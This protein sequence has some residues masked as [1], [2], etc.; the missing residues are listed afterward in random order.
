MKDHKHDIER[1]LS[2]GMTPAEMHA[3]E[4]AALSDPFLADALEGA[5]NI[6][7]EDFLDDVRALKTRGVRK[8]KPTPAWS[9]PLRIAA[10]LVV[11]VVASFFLVW[12]VGNPL[13]ENHDLAMGQK[14]PGKEKASPE[15]TTNAN[16]ATP[17]GSSPAASAPA[18]SIEGTREAAVESKQDESNGVEGSAKVEENAKAAEKNAQPTLIAS[19]KKVDTSGTSGVGVAQQQPVGLSSASSARMADIALD[20]VTVSARTIRGKVT[21]G[22]ADIAGATISTKNGTSHAVSDGTGNY[23]ITV[24]DSNP[25]LVFSS[26]GYKSK[27]IDPGLATVVN[28]DLDSDLRAASEQAIEHSP[29]QM[30]GKMQLPSAHAQS[31]IGKDDFDKYLA[32]NVQYPP[33]A[34]AKQVEGRV[35]VEFTVDATGALKDFKIIKGIGSGCDEELIRLIRTGPPWTPAQLGGHAV[36]EQVRLKFKFELPR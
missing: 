36:D 35:T 3:L 6:S 14:T 25:A 13:Y 20:S 12:R 33:A 26:T 28:A 31:S 21:S 9:W 8:V 34:L 4:R 7:G 5:E 29:D 23:E 32:A 30:Q 18:N 24:T 19:Q 10:A 17:P 1:Y 16:K 11:L 22:G 2:G 27:E 15:K